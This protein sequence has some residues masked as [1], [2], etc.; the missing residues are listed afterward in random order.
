[1]SELPFVEDSLEK[2]VLEGAQRQRQ[3]AIEHSAT[4]ALQADDRLSRQNDL[5]SQ[6]HDEVIELRERMEWLHRH[7]RLRHF[8]GRSAVTITFR[9]NLGVQP[10][11]PDELSTPLLL[12]G[13]RTVTGAHELVHGF[14]FWR[15]FN[16]YGSQN[17]YTLYAEQAVRDTT[18]GY[19][20]RQRLYDMYPYEDYSGPRVQIR[21]GAFDDYADEKR[22]QAYAMFKVNNPWIAQYPGIYP[23]EL[24][25]GQRRW[26]LL[27]GRGPQGQSY[28]ERE[29]QENQIYRELISQYEP[30]RTWNY[31]ND[32]FLEPLNLVSHANDILGRK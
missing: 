25:S 19:Q 5:E 31:P 15:F 3:G 27:S 21:G 29:A 32:M 8:I 1:M 2:R 13:E 28:R 17:P 18:T 10:G 24:S 6:L 30:G 14:V 9:S 12:E 26:A 23:H 11:I 20:E 16:K 4:S 22:S 7:P